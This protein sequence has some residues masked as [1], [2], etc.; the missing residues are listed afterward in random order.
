MRPA[1]VIRRKRDGERLSREAIEA[2]V[3][4]Y[5]RG[6]IPDY[7]MAAWLMAVWFRGMDARETADLTAAMVASG[8]MLDL[9]PIGRPVVDKHSTGGVGDKTTLVVAPM[10]AACGVPVAKLSGRGLGHTGGTLDKLESI[11]GL[12]VQLS[13]E[14]LLEQV[15]AVGLAVAGQTAELC[16]ADGL[17]YALRDVTATIDSIPLI[18]SSIMAKKVA[19]G[20][21]A[22]VLDVKVGRGAFM[23]SLGDAMTLARAMV[24]IG[25]RV[26]RRTVALLTAMDQPLGRAVGNA[27]EVGEAIAALRGAGPADLMAVATAL[28]AEMLVLGGAAPDLDAARVRLD[29]AVASGAALERFRAMI[30]AQGGD[31]GVCDDPGRLPLAPVTVPLPAPS[32]GVVAALDAR[33]VGE[34]VLDLGAGRRTKADPVDPA[35]GV[36]LHKKVG[37]PVAAGEPLATVHARTAAAAEAAARTLLGAYQLDAAAAGAGAGSPAVILGRIA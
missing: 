26:G 25:A 10:V 30:A 5:A 20:A 7:Q 21:H 19:G 8:R 29:E 6:E 27:L 33:R 23:A 36:V 16:P 35:V 22:I 14:R 4:G 1:E 18:A 2:F 13:A 12:S 31:P 11:P 15:R 37:D 32:A 17:M 34:A 28:A 24:D 3:L 9:T